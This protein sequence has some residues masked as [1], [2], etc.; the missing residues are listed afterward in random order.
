MR[1]L[2][3]C[4]T[5]ARVPTPAGLAEALAALITDADLR[6]DK[7]RR[8]ETLAERAFSWDREKASLLAAYARLV[9]SR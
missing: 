4:G 7:G 2:G 9:P 8:S 1:L 3:D 6:A 5:Y